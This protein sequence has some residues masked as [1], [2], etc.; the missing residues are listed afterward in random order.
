M[1]TKTEHLTIGEEKENRKV[2]VAFAVWLVATIIAAGIMDLFFEGIPLGFNVPII[3]IEAS[4]SMI[5]YYSA[6]L[7][8]AI[9][10]GIVGLKELVIERR[11]SVEFLMA[12]A[13]LGALGLD[14]RFEAATV[15]FLYCLAEYFE[16]YLQDRAKR[17]VEK[18]SKVIPETARLIEGD[19]AETVDVSKVP[20]NAL[21][22]VRPGERIPLDGVVVDGFSHVDQTIVTGESVPVP[23]KINDLVYAGTL[24]TGGVLKITVSKKST[25]TLV[26]RIVQLVIESQKRKATIERL[27]DRFAKVYVPII[28]A[29]ALFTALAMPYLVGGGFETWFYR[30]LILLVVSCPSAFIISVPATVF[31][32]I[33]IA[34][35]R[36]VI[37]KGGI[38][39]EKMA[40]VKRVVF[41]KTGTLTLGR[42]AVHEIRRV[43]VTSAE[44]DA[45]AYAAA[46]DQYSNH[47]IAQ[48]IV[49]KALERKI[50]LS[51]IKVT[52]VVEVPGKGIVGLVNDK[53][54]AIGTL[55]FMKELGC[56]CTQAFEITSGDIHTAVCVSVGKVGLAAV[57]VADE[58]RE[59]AMRSVRRLKD[60]GIKTTMLTGDKTEIANDTAQSIGIDEVYAELLPEEKLARMEEFKGKDGLVAMVGDGV[61]D[62]PALAASD[63]GIA[64]GA[65]GVDVALESADVVLVKDELSQ[66][67]YIL[68]LSQKT[69]VIAKQNIAA[70][71][72]VKLIL[73]ALG[74]LGIT[75][76]W[77]TV[78]SGDDGVTMLLLLNSLRLE[79]VK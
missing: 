28:I 56:D 10:I 48:A 41:D 69:M 18:I 5:L 79:R 17:T 70:S 13:G 59:D 8:A 62:A 54:V 1:D 73:G 21:I 12:V 42:Q 36:G 37:I 23:K 3:N 24:N 50:D 40:K 58:V 20:V 14:Y 72:V 25:E 6:V 65:R 75:P 33:T 7:V 45:I 68:R 44:D 47:P 32:A 35:K 53:Q 66:I 16:G 22:L 55:E 76:L 78:A 49:R 67:P 30:S 63:V 38:F 71:L 52:D 43:D 26:S 9:Y 34:A 11:F 2:L 39:I 15:L 60:A 57:C 74:L 64:M 61:N 29:L 51:K 4:V 19:R 27:V 31:V 77:F 46:L